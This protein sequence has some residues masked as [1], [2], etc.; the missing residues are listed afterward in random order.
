MVNISNNFNIIQTSSVT[1]VTSNN[2]RAFL[3]NKPDTFEKSTVTFSNKLKEKF[4][5]KQ[6]ERLAKKP[7]EIQEKANILSNTKLSADDITFNLYYSNKDLDA[8]KVADKV[9]EMEKVCGENLKDIKLGSN[10]YDDTCLDITA[11]TNDNNKKILTIDKKGKPRS[12]EDVIYQAKNGENFEIKKSKDFK[13]GMISEITSKVVDNKI[14]PQ[15]EL[16]I[17]KDYKEYAEPS[18]IK[19][20]F[21]RTRTYNNGKVEEISSGKIDKKTGIKTVKKNMTSLDGTKTEY[22]FEDDPKGNRISDY[23]ITDKSGKVL[24]NNSEA[25]EVID[26][27][28]FI[29]SKNDK[30]YEI[31]YSEDNKKLN[32][33]DRKT[34]QNTEIDLYNYILGGNSEKLIPALKTVSGDELIKMKDNV[35]H[36][37][38]IDDDTASFY[39]PSRKDVTTC[40]TPYILLH[41][42]GHAK[43]MKQYD[44]TS[45]KTKDA[46]ESLLV[47]ANKDVKE[48]YDKERE[49]FNKNFSNA[50]REHVD[51]FIKTSGHP[52][53]TNG[54]LKES[55][56]EV[57]AFLNTPNS[58][59][60]YSMRAEYLQRYFPKTVAKLAEQLNK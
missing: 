9:I 43:D 47:S 59:D 56:A 55:L 50:Q 28:T 34:N 19:G 27:N 51:Y 40:D 33:K 2:N 39:H 24:Y 5:D 7:I 23:K 52:S 35:T 45:F 16:I 8:K 57:N 1:N 17:A 36:L 41:E 37:L 26:E 48:T 10:K 53:G 30:S 13:T 21:N 31:K 11:I 6:L 4:D 25:F 60:R 20:I 54:A 3:S 12:S 32:V 58:V 49:L 22:L 38:Q 46:T 44:T 15:T 18:E 14:I 29:S 42:L